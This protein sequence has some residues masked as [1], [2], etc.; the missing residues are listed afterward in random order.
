MAALFQRAQNGGQFLGGKADEPVFLGLHIQTDKEVEIV[1]QRGDDS[2]DR[3]SAVGHVAVGGDHEGGRAHDG[4]HE[5]AAAGGHGLHGAGEVALIAA[6]L[7]QGDGERTGAD[8]VGHGR[9]GDHAEQAAADHGRLRRAAAVAAHQAEGHVGEQL[10]AAGLLQ[11]GAEQNKQNDIRCGNADRHA[12]NAVSAGEQSPDYLIQSKVFAGED[13]GD[14]PA[15]ERVQQ[16]DHRY[17][18][19]GKADGPAGQLEDQQH[20][21]DAYDGIH[22]VDEAEVA[23]DPVPVKEQIDAASCH[24]NGADNIVEGHLVGVA[25]RVN[26]VE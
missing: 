7:H 2:G 14:V 24:Q 4:G 12:E 26:S 13:T 21:D 6:A 23:R 8:H 5:L 1:E 25:R 18:D 20:Q 9:A 17:D 10:T 11:E 22:G 3:H 16:E 19:K 15:E